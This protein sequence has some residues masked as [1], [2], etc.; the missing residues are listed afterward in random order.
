[1]ARGRFSYEAQRVEW[2]ILSCIVSGMSK[3]EVLRKQC[4]LNPHPHTVRD[5]LFSSDDFFDPCDLPQVK[6]EMLR[7][8][9]HDK[10]PV[11]KV[12]SDFGFSRVSFYQARSAFQNEG[13]SGL[14]PRKRGPKDRHKLTGEVMRFVNETRAGEE[15]T[16]PVLLAQR[17]KE[18]FGIR[19]HPRSL[20]RAVAAQKK[21]LPD[22]HGMASEAN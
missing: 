13:L 9:A 11:S 2:H 17:I 14:L 18:R 22:R 7:R 19:V 16:G 4:C 12:A 3:Q 6:Y 1:V 20:Q 5:E 15:S 10:S 8:V 21:K